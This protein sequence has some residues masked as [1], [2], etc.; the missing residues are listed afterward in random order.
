MFGL[1]PAYAIVELDLQQVIPPD[2]QISTRSNI[3]QMMAQTNDDN[4]RYSLLLLPIFRYV[5]AH[6]FRYAVG[7]LAVTQRN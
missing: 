5:N 4:W 3:A 6:E 7:R 2:W 1:E